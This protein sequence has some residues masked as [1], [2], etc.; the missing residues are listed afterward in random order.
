MTPPT[1]NV[2]AVE[3]LVPLTKTG[4]LSSDKVAPLA[5]V[6]VSTKVRPLI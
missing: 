3:A 5:E 4:V 2:V 1:V 6:K